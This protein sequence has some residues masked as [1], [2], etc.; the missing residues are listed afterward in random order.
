MT[1]GKEI[2]DM[3]ERCGTEDGDPKKRVI[4]SDC[5]EIKRDGEKHVQTPT[6]S[7]STTTTSTTTV[8]TTA[9]SKESKK[10]RLEQKTDE[11]TTAT[12]K[13]GKSSKKR[14][15]SEES[16]TSLKKQ[17]SKD[18]IKKVARTVYDKIKKNKKNL[19]EVIASQKK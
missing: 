12:K 6:S 2:V 14:R 11:T 7:S 16:S 1:K 15:L 9:G 19:K 8:A 5:G 17:L 18:E 10:R 4:I 13:K 3:I